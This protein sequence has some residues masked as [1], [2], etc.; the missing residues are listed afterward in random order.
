MRSIPLVFLL[1]GTFVALPALARPPAPKPDNLLDDRFGVQVAFSSS[2]NTTDFRVDAFDGT[3]GT[4]LSAEDDFGMAA[5]KTL[6]R[7]DIWFRMRE[8]HRVRLS[9]YF[10]SLDRRGDTVLTQPIRF[11]DEVY[12]ARERVLSELEIRRQSITYTYSF[13]KNDRVEA[14]VSIG[15]ESVQFDALAAV[16]ARLRT[17]R[18]ERA[19]PAPLGGLE[20]AARVSGPWYVEGRLQYVKAGDQDVEGSLTTYELSGLWRYNP[21]VT[22]GFGWNSFRIDV[23]SRQVGDAGRLRLQTQG[24]QVFARFGF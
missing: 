2:R 19:A 9:T 12:L 11:G 20:F 16:P 10:L 13:V 22:F 6:G 17:E 15:V 18:E 7:G 14:G 21:N 8:R 1:A 23:D 3:P 5:R 4:D 24:P